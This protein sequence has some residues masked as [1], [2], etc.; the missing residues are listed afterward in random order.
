MSVTL[1][2][3]ESPQQRPLSQ[4]GGRRRCRAIGDWQDSWRALREIRH[5]RLV[6]HARTMSYQVT[7]PL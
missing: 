2:K 5:S 4:R 1:Q 3:D 6:N 7:L